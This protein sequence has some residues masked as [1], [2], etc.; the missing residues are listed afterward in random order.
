MSISA[1]AVN[2][3][4]AKPAPKV[5]A[6]SILSSSAF[7]IGLPVL[8]CSACFSSTAGTVSQCS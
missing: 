6:A 4:V 3:T 5:R 8:T 2:S 1:D 7:G